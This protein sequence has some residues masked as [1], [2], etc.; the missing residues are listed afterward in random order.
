MANLVNDLKNSPIKK[1]V[2]TSIE[3]DCKSEKD[4]EEIYS[5]V[6]S[7]LENHLEEFAKI[8]YELEG[9][10]KVKVEVIQ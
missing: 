6:Y 8:T 1:H 7:I 4:Q 5:E 10:N 9:D 3:Y 2:V